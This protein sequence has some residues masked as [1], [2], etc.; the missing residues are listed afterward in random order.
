MEDEGGRGRKKRKRVTNRKSTMEE[1]QKDDEEEEG[2]LRGGKQDEKF[3]IFEIPVALKESVLS[4]VLFDF[5][6]FRFGS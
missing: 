2:E 3:N 1:E 4:G 6:I 5:I